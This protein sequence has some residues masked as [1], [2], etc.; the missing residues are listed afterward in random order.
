[1]IIKKKHTHNESLSLYNMG[2]MNLCH[3]PLKKIFLLPVF[4]LSTLYNNM[5]VTF[6]NLIR[7]TQAWTL[8]FWTH[9]CTEHTSWQILTTFQSSLASSPP[10]M[11]SSRTQRCCSSLMHLSSFP[12]VFIKNFF[13]YWRQCFFNWNWDSL[14]LQLALYFVA[15]H[16][17]GF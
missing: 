16:S 9:R 4:V 5:I 3:R 13:F 11:S 7:V 6:N 1:M 12:V 17:R 2:H 14:W 8:T 10:S 15:G